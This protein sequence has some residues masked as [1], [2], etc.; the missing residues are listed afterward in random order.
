M[1]E[2][3]PHGGTYYKYNYVKF[4]FSSIKQPG[5]YYIQYGDTKTNDFII[6]KSVYD[7]ITDATTDIWIP[8]HMN[9]MYVNE[10]CQSTGGHW[11]N[12]VFPQTVDRRT[13]PP[14]RFLSSPTP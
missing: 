6:D 14:A 13:S 5:V 4:D 8:I 10:G 9:H 1:R 2:P 12:K 3:S 7:K 11:Y